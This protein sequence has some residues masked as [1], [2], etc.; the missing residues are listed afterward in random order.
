[1]VEKALVW[2]HNPPVPERMKNGGGGTDR[3]I[4]AAVVAHM[5]CALVYLQA[6]RPRF[7]RAL[8]FLRL[9]RVWPA[10]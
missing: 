3:N 7:Y 10:V 1:M 6:Q 5:P 8:F 2:R 4:L 9:G